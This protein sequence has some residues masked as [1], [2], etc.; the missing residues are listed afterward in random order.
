M[1]NR[2]LRGQSHTS[3]ADHQDKKFLKKYPSTKLNY[4]DYVKEEPE[5]M[6]HQKPIL[7]N[8]SS[9]R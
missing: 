7:S 4:G 6:L 1:S 8:L 5:D 9:K 3:N 2:S